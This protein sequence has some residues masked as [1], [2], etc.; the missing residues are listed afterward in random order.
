MGGH[1]LPDRLRAL[2]LRDRDVVVEGALLG[3][4][5]SL[6]MAYARSG[7]DLDMIPPRFPEVMG[8]QQ[9]RE[10]ITGF[11]EVGAFATAEVDINAILYGNVGPGQEGV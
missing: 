10:I 11:Q 4:A 7:W 6:A 9:K 3:A 2:P 1:L 5:T 8:P